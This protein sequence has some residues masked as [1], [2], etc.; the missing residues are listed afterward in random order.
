MYRLLILFFCFIVFTGSAQVND[1]STYYER[2]G[3]KETPRYKETMDYCRMLEKNSNQVHLVSFG[4][5]S[6]GRDLPLLIVDREGKSDPASIH[7][8]GKLILLIQACIHPG[9]CEGK[10]AGLMFIRDLVILNKYP[11]LLDHVSILFI[12]IFNVDGHERFAPNNRINQNGPDETGWRTTA[13]NLNLN[14]DY[15]KADAPEMKAWLKMFSTWLPDFFIDTHTT[16]GADYQYVLTYHM[17]VYGN[18]DPGLTGW[19]RD[20][21][22]KTWSGKMENEGFHVFP[23]VEFRNWHDPQSGLETG[24]SPPMLSQGYTSLR[25]RPGLLIETHMLKPYDQRVSSTYEA[26]KSALEILSE[27][28][29]NLKNLEQKADAYVSSAGFRKQWFPLRFETTNDSTTVQFL[30]IQYHK[31]KST[32]TGDDFYRFG[33]AKTTFNIPFFNKTRVV[34]SARLPEAYIIP[35]EWQNVISRIELHGIR[36]TRLKQDTNLMVTGWKLS[37]PR[38]QT[39]PYEGRHPLTAFDPSGINV[40]RTFP[41][42]SAI[43]DMAQPE[44][45]IIAQML[46]PRGN[47]SLI[48]WGFFDAIFEQ[49]EYAE[50]YVMEPLAAKMLAEDPALKAEF[51]KKKAT[52]TAFAK[53]SD[54]ILNWFYNKSQYGDPFRELYPIG[55]LY[56]RKAVDGLV[57]MSDN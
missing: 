2:S 50:N 43:I 27:E 31:V 53:N 15:L 13:L 45:R 42:G 14:R 56:D 18:M 49:K 16:D 25:N 6:K 12:P 22:L 5:S 26:L 37:N 10:D 34:D 32:V 48:Y 54:A 40:L 19:I 30:G 52:D 35:A 44:A 9:E 47:G 46:E 4:K 57:K 7:A 24:A 38:W 11:G 39:N 51:E 28:A 41:A 33:K 21:F 23:Y 55:R 3:K 29:G 36:I 20:P 1:W 17:E 8:S